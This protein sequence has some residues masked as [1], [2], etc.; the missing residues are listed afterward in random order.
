MAGEF[1][2]E[3]D[4]PRE[5]TITREIEYSFSIHFIRRL[6]R[7]STKVPTVTAKPSALP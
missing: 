3:K 4:F 1:I 5:L 6:P 2:D 7:P